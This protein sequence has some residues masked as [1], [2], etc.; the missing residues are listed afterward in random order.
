MKIVCVVPTIRPQQMEKF[1]EAWKG[2]FAKHNVTLITVWDGEDPGISII[3]DDLDKITDGKPNVHHLIDGYEDCF[4]RFTDSCRNYGFVAAAKLNPDYILTLD[5]DVEPYDNNGVYPQPHAIKMGLIPDPIQAHLDVLNKR[6]SLSWMNTAD[7]RGSADYNTFE[8]MR[9]FPYSTRN[10]A[11]VMLSHGV[12]TGVPDLDGETQLKHTGEGGRLPIFNL[13]Y[14]NGPIPKGVLFP[15]CGMNM[16]I[17]REALPYFYFA[18]MGPDTGLDLHRFGDI[19]MGIHLK[20]AFDGFNWACYTGGSTVLHTRASDAK[21]NVE[22]EK[23]GREWNEWI[24]N[25]L[26]TYDKIT[27]FYS[28]SLEEKAY[29]DYM[30]SY[31]QKR[32]QYAGLIQEVMK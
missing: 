5:D 9:G 4:Y 22:Q 11:P 19:W 3:G 25:Q 6:V 14:Y 26:M 32:K 28:P 16:M 30:E 7:Y 23:L 13:T 17:R 24:Q 20:S 1:R 18:P 31:E 15:L 27:P 2:L 29:N 10:E 8:Y 12:W 21:K